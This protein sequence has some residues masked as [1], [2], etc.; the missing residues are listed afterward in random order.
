MK[1]L[2]IGDI[3]GK[4][5]R[6]FLSNN[7]NNL[8][9]KYQPD[10]IIANGE[11]S[12]NGKGITKK[13][14]NYLIDIGVDCITLGN[15]SFAK[16]ELLDYINELKFLIRPYNYKYEDLGNK[17]LIFNI[18]KLKVCIVN[19]IGSAFMVGITKDP[20]DA[21][22]EILDNIKAD[23]YIVDFHAEA[24]GEKLLIANYYSNRI[25]ALIG[26]H[27]H[28]QTTD[29]RI[30]NKLGYISDVGMTGPYNSILGR[31]TNEVIDSFIYKKKT[32]YKV[33]EGDCILNGIILE[34]DEE[35]NKTI[36]IE[37]IN[38]IE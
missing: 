38:I 28:I 25:H 24:N 6:E 19:I 31:D 13:I 30:I 8:K 11:N 36:S 20:I 12:A 23:I 37:R 22:D 2:F 27:T 1:I 17:Y 29:N 9:E 7:I 26:T 35:T 3:V 34:I 16:K 21:I 18:N 5:G 15:H 32:N 14:Y 10:L 4:L 33:A